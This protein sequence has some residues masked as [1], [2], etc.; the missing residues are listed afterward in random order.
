MPQPLFI[1]QECPGVG[2]DATHQIPANKL[3]A[4]YHCRE[5]G[6]EFYFHP[7]TSRVEIGQKPAHFDDP[8]ILAPPPKWRPNLYERLDDFWW[9]LKPKHRDWARLGIRAAGFLTAAFVISSFFRPSPVAPPDL[10]L[11]SKVVMRAI[12]DG[13]PG[14][15]ADVSEGSLEDRKRF[16]KAARPLTWP[17]K[18]GI[19][20]A[21]FRL[22]YKRPKTREGAVGVDVGSQYN[23]LPEENPPLPPAAESGE[24]ADGTEASPVSGEM[25]ATPSKNTQ[26][27][28]PNT[29]AIEGAPEGEMAGDPSA[30]TEKPEAVEAKKDEPPPVKFVL[31]WKLNA[32]NEWMLD[33]SRKPIQ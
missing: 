7:T 22:L 27:S 29:P 33:L 16:I 4:Q 5:C 26:A 18:L 28:P 10:E 2:C 32:Y 23:P 13:D 15:L 19:Y 9:S 11:R 24:A 31:H 1:L 12:A 30:T 6:V 25:E 8:Y 3:G 17:K 14:K 21:E 20:T